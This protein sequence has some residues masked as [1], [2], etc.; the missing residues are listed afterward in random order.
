MSR[1]QLVITFRNVHKCVPRISYL[2]IWKGKTWETCYLR[3]IKYNL[4]EPTGLHLNQPGHN[5][6]HASFK[7]TDVLTSDPDDPITSG[8]RNK[9][10]LYWIMQLRTIKPHGISPVSTVITD[11]IFTQVLP[12]ITV[13]TV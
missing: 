12:L 7:I 10:G 1:V 5:I 9:R 11:S 8:Q 4:D 6:A 2:R 3:Y 13:L